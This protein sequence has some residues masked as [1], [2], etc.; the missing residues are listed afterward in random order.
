MRRI[1]V[2]AAALACSLA[3]PARAQNF[4]PPESDRPNEEYH[5][6][7]RFAL[8]LKFGLYSPHIDDTPGLNGRPFAELFNN[9]Y[10]DEPGKQPAGKGLFTVEF[11][12]QFWRPFGSFGLAV[13]AGYTGRK[14]HSFEYVIDANG[15]RQ[16]RLADGECMRSGDTTQLNI[17]PVTLELVYRFDVLSLRYHIPIVPYIKAG[18]A[19]YIWFIQKGDGGVSTGLPSPNNDPAR[20]MSE[21]Q[22]YGGVPGFVLHPG[23]ML[24]LDAFDRKAAQTLDAELGI[25]HTYLFAELNYAN[26]AGLGIFKD[27][28]T[29]SDTTWNAGLAFEF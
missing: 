5:S 22:A 2:A 6:P 9:Q 16:C 19:Y 26:I 13:S 14:S 12:W 20:D 18:L 24:L 21:W 29:L 23:V 28:I 4:P 25:N 7:Q 8:E 11:D 17:F 27:K 10:T 1:A 3:S 15:P